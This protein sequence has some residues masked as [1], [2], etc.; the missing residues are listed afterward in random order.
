VNGALYV[1]PWCG[2]DRDD[3]EADPV[4]ADP[5]C[6]VCGT[7]MEPVQWM[8]TGQLLTDPTIDEEEPPK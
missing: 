7:D 4:N 1:C 6:P 5:T 3:Y 2:V 8:R